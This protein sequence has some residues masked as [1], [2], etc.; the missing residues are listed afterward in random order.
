MV[1]VTDL[2]DL[3]LTH[4]TAAYLTC[5]YVCDVNSHTL[6]RKKVKIMKNLRVREVERV[7]WGLKRIVD[8]YIVAEL[9]ENVAGIVFTC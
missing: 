6:A 1:G 8:E 7:T 2:S 4:S 9:G 5:F 3:S